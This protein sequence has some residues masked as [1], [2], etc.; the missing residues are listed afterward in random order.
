M[1]EEKVLD[2]LERIYGKALAE[3]YVAG[4]ENLLAKP[5]PRYRV[6]GEYDPHERGLKGV[7]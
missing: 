2:A 4:N 6:V 5:E 7:E 1:A 3:A